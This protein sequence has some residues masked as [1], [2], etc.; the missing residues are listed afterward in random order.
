MEINIHSLSYIPAKK[1]NFCFYLEQLFIAI[2]IA[3]NVS[4]S[5]INALVV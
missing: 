1:L 5:L 3:P 2:S 4:I